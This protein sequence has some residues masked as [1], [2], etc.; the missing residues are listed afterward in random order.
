MA[1][2]LL[3]RHGRLGLLDQD[4]LHG[5]EQRRGTRAGQLSRFIR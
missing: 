2:Q 5:Y 3:N 1:C 4:L